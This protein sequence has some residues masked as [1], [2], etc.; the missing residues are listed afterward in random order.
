MAVLFYRQLLLRHKTP[1]FKR[2]PGERGAAVL[3]PSPRPAPP[4]E[5]TFIINVQSHEFDMSVTT[6]WVY[7]FPLLVKNNVYWLQTSRGIKD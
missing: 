7:F 1:F 3:H 6:I 5:Y 2:Q 4:A